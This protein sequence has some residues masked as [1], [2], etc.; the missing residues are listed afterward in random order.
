M[1]RSVMLAV[2]AGLLWTNT[3]TAH[4][5]EGKAAY[6]GP[7][8]K[9]YVAIKVGQFKP[10]TDYGTTSSGLKNFDPGMN[11]EV[12]VGQKS[13]KYFAFDVGLGYYS[14]SAKNGS[15]AKTSVLDFT[16]SAL[17]IL[18]IS[19]VDLFA[20][21]GGGVYS[22]TLKA[23]GTDATSEAFGYQL[24]AGADINITRS[25]ALGGEVKYSQ[26]KPEFKAVP[27]GQKVKINVGGTTYNGVLK[28]KF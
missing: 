15:G 23:A 14:V 21:I 10:N 26:A 8:P 2:A 27:S 12:A 9:G 5:E 1:K 7:A 19:S 16:V 28:Y 6:E 11:Y 3:F 20:G 17:G 18:P 25:I 4:A 24:L 22:A 13:S